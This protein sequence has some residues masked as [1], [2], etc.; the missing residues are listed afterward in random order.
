MRLYLYVSQNNK[1]IFPFT[2]FSDCFYN[3]DKKRLLR[4]TNF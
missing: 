2:A 4:G 1:R 3:L